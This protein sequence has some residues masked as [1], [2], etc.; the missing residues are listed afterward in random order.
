M[1]KIIPLSLES[2][3]EIR[4]G[5]LG[6][7]IAK[8]LYKVATDLE[9]GGPDLPDKRT[10]T[11]QVEFEPVHMQG[12]LDE[13]SVTFKV[14][15]KLPPRQCSQSMSVRSMSNGARMLHFNVESPDEVDQATLD[16]DESEAND[17]A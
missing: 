9:V 2:L 4:G 1:L 6:Q 3:G 13:V 7:M 8:E 17:E 16:F 10:L 5:L 12:E 11:M 15:S 14:T